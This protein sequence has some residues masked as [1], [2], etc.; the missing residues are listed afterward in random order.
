MSLLT[1][2]KYPDPR[3]AEESLD[4]EE[5]GDELKALA[6]DMCETMISAPGVGL[7]APQV[8]RLLRVI[9]VDRSDPEDEV[10]RPEPLVL[11]NPEI[12]HA[13][14]SQVFRE[15]C[16]SVE[17]FQSDVTRYLEVEV[18]AQDLDGNFFT[19]EAEGR[20]AVILQ[21]EID[22]LDGVLF[23]DHVSPLKRS[24]YTKSLLKRRSK[25]RDGR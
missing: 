5:F 8:G 11:V 14:G 6:S 24:M 18:E 4:V 13:D 19:V 25:D 7:A 17:D 16:L 20:M 9:V 22:H 12:V 2:L 10:R 21:H 23:L 15:G 1:I 3:L